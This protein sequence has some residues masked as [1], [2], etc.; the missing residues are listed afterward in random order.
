MRDESCKNGLVRAR[1]KHVESTNQK[2]SSQVPNSDMQLMRLMAGL[3]WCTNMPIQCSA[4]TSWI[5]LK[6]YWPAFFLHFSS[7]S[8]CC[9]HRAQTVVQEDIWW[10]K[11]HKT[12][13]LYLVFRS[14]SR[15]F[16]SISASVST[17]N[18]GHQCSVSCTREKWQQKAWKIMGSEADQIF[19]N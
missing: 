16:F 9:P 15:I 18:R 14:W 6:H 4:S 5:I 3:T 2:I 17:S 12:R 1:K 10:R 11:L 8:I 19:M 13:I 7:S